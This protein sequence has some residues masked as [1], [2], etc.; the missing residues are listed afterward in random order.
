MEKEISAK[1]GIVV[2]R[3]AF[4]GPSGTFT[5]EALDKW[6][7]LIYREKLPYPTV[8]EA[9][10]A[11][12]EGEAEKAV[13]PIENSI[14][15][16]VNDT[17]DALAFEVDLRIEAELVHPVR[18]CLMVRPGVSLEEVEAVISHP[19]AAAQCR[20]HL[21]A[22]LP[23]VP[24]EAANST[25]EAAKRVA[26]STKPLAALGSRA[27]GDLYGLQ[28]AREGMEDHPENR[29]R[30]VLVGRERKPPSGYDKTSIVC[31]IHQDR[32]G[33]LLQILQEFAY[34]Y[35]N[36]TKIESR[37]TKKVLGEYCFFIDCEGHEEDEVVASALRCLRCKLPVVKMLGSYPRYREE[38]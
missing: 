12:A 14:E 35:I 1:P 3:L 9:L 32:P 18:H 21:K 30:F 26:E 27:A 36:L 7:G 6:P 17:L 24:L 33:M 23:G 20:R 4:L 16:S 38:G 37:P 31:F 8:E 13:V 11:V 15:G 10:F 2:R 19:Q 22:T 28:V 5:E 29:T 34:R 25:A